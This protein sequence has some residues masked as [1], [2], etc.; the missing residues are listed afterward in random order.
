M[1]SAIDFFKM[2]ILQFQ[3]T[4]SNQGVIEL[5]RYLF[6]ALSEMH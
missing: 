3:K 1:I 2:D 6:V 4:S 5:G